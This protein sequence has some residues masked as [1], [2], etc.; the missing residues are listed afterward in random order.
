MRRAKGTCWLVIGTFLL[1]CGARPSPAHAF[2]AVVSHPPGSLQITEAR[3]AVAAADGRR[4]VWAQLRAK[5]SPTAVAWV[6]PLPAGGVLDAGSSSFLDALEDAT[7]PRIAPPA[8]PP[9]GAVCELPAAAETITN[10]DAEPFLYPERVT[11]ASTGAEVTKVLAKWGF[12]DTDV[13]TISA[14]EGSSFVVLRFAPPKGAFATFTVRLW[15]VA[16]PALP[17]AM[18][19]APPTRPLLT[20]TF[21]LGP[22]KAGF[23]T[24]TLVKEV[25][26]SAIVWRSASGTTYRETRDALLAQEQGAF[27]LE[28][29]DSS[30]FTA[31]KTLGPVAVP[32]LV[33]AYLDRLRERGET[34]VDREEAEDRILGEIAS[35]TTTQKPCPR[36]DL[37]GTPPCAKSSH[38]LAVDDLSDDLAFAFEAPTIVTR[39]AGILGAKESGVDLAVTFTTDPTTHPVVREPTVQYPLLCSSLP[40]TPGPTGAGGRKGG[41]DAKG[42]RG[43]A[44]GADGALAD[45]ATDDAGSDAQ[46]SV[47]ILC[48]G[49]SRGT[50]QDD[51]CSSR[52]TT[53]DSC[54]SKNDHTTTDSCG[55]SDDGGSCK[56]ADG[57]DSCGSGSGGGSDSCSNADGSA[58]SGCDSGGSAAGDSCG[59]CSASGGRASKR[60]RLS[61]LGLAASAL[62]LFLRRSTR[63]KR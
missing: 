30:T 2:G 26:G 31:R 22:G 17:Q 21:L 27:V 51:A 36:G 54:S 59:K 42:G 47:G 53:S 32:S 37:A 33:E 3:T 4:T 49:S 16:S 12:A 29:A 63:R 14:P 11:L 46:T 34:V 10:G 9:K 15:S 35:R 23:P 18:L 52:D 41:G 55:G 28:S 13:N 24:G 25:A 45:D 20:T 5:G 38:P 61:P 57:T 8:P 19:E 6:L 7:A 58:P 43:N 40:T 56:N 39:F 60:V 62:A 50:A 48:D 44:Q 1:A